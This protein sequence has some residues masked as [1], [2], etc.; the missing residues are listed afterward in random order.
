MQ[1]VAKILGLLS[2]ICCAA[3]A[4][5]AGKIQE[6]ELSSQ[7][8]RWTYHLYTPTAIRGKA[9][10]LV[11]VFHGAGGNG[12]TY[13]EK[14]GWIGESERGGFAVAAPDG[15]P[16]FPSL[17]SNFR[18]NPRLWNS[19][20]L[21]PESP[22]AKINDITF[23]EALLDDITQREKIDS[24]RVF[25]AGHS[26]GAG[27]TF[28]V[29]A[30]LSTRFAALATVMGQN[31]V[32]DARP[33]RSLPTFVMLGTDD[34]LNPLGGGTRQLPWGNSTVPPPA[35]GIAAWSS[36]L[37]CAPVAQTVRAD[38][39][40]RAERYGDCRDGAQLLVW[41]LL[42]QGHAWPMGKDSGLP[43]SVMGP[44]PTRI[45]ATHEIWEFFLTVSAPHPAPAVQ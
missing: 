23:V 7:G 9:V 5:D 29:G 6:L 22:R 14:N 39:G 2:L 32:T 38:A 36:A 16:A 44:N 34:P 33:Q 35:D 41:Y 42:G 1:V 20:Q 8:H 12:R 28:L 13:L 24:Q 25:A 3:S 11:L 19:G 26:N 45:N 21:K 37:G 43:E 30:R 27:M 31:S 4:S 18:F 15:L 40:V 17:P 10:P